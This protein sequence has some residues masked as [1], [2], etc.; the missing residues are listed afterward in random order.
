M[1]LCISESLESHIAQAAELF[2]FHPQLTHKLSNGRLYKIVDKLCI[3]ST[4]LAR[5]VRLSQFC[6]CY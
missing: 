2:T 3:R 6:N 4:L 5:N 1:F